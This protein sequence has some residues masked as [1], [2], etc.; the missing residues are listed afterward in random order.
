MD[1]TDYNG[2]TSL[3]EEQ[4]QLIVTVT[5]EHENIPWTVVMGTIYL[6]CKDAKYPSYMIYFCKQKVENSSKK[7]L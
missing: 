7:Q 6:A 2:F 1:Q 3:S 5:L 4:G